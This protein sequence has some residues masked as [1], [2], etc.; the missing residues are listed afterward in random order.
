MDYNNLLKTEGNTI[1]WDSDRLR[2]EFGRVFSEVFCVEVFCYKN[3][4]DQI[5]YFTIVRA[6]SIATYTV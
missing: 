6:S 3:I 5:I 2:N 1:W 4:L